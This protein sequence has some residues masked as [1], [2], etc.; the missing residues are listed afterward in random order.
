MFYFVRIPNDFFELRNE[1]V[2]LYW[3][4]IVDKHTQFLAPL[5]SYLG[6]NDLV[7]TTSGLRAPKILNIMPITETF[8]LFHL[9]LPKMSSRYHPTGQPVF[10]ADQGW[11]C[12][13]K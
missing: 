7:K 1:D 5:L 4:A 9:L 2:L 8:H 6:I 11:Y 10:Q 13:K 12:R 3:Y